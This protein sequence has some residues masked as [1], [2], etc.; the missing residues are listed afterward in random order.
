MLI[1]WSF[2]FAS[3]KYQ[4]I[5]KSVPNQWSLDS[6][7]FLL[8][9]WAF[10]ICWTCFKTQVV[11]SVISELFFSVYI[12]FKYKAL[13]LWT[14]YEYLGSGAI[15]IDHE[16]M[17]SLFSVSRDLLWKKIAKNHLFWPTKSINH[18]FLILKIISWCTILKKQKINSFWINFY[19]LSLV[20]IR[21]CC[22][23]NIIYA[24]RL[25]K[26]QS[27]LAL[28][29]G[30]FRKKVL[31]KLLLRNSKGKK[32]GSNQFFFLWKSSRRNCL[33]E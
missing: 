17:G 32:I 26:L 6:W 7:T 9:S 21:N 16:T 1:G 18:D 22:R 28:S 14:Y 27:R 5:F 23:R 30:F 33:F 31:R 24:L 10:L 11:G 25:N 20:L 4:V 8:S 13:K 3:V 2:L 15:K 12:L 19:K 29:S